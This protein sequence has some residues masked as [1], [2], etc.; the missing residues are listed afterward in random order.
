MD[1]ISIE[2]YQHDWI[3][4]FA[5]FRDDG[6]VA[7]GKAHVVINVGGLLACVASGDIPA[8][9]IPYMVAETLMHEIVH[10]LEAWADVE[11]N[12]DRVEAL[13]E[14]YTAER[15]REEAGNEP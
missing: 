7:E 3:P 11:F 10:V 14:K 1:K 8:A 9:D 4:G 5:A 12:E 6:I 13:I 15:M 2:V